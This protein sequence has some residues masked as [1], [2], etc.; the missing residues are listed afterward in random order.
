MM[1]C[2]KDKPTKVICYLQFG[3][4]IT[5][6][7]KHDSKITFS[8]NVD[9]QLQNNHDSQTELVVGWLFGFYGILTFV[10]YLTSNPFLLK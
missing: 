4:N 8:V 3:L 5:L 2:V 7:I 9:P 6:S 1:F 10:G